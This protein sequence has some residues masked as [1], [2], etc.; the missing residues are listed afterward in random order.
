MSRRCFL[1]SLVVAL[2]ATPAFVLPAQAQD[3][4]DTVKS[5]Y[6]QVYVDG[7][8]CPFCAYGLEKKLGKLGAIQTMEVQLENGRVLLA[9]K[10]G[11]LQSRRPSRAPDLRAERSSSRT[12]TREKPPHRDSEC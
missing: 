7:L 12:S 5:P 2:L 1:V 9:F 3:R 8:T 4:G 6:A 11:Q 10:E